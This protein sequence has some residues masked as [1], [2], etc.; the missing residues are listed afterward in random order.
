MNN[1]PYFPCIFD[2]KCNNLTNRLTFDIKLLDQP[3]LSLT[4]VRFI[5]R[6]HKSRLTGIKECFFTDEKTI[7]KIMDLLSDAEDLSGVVFA[8]HAF[9]NGQWVRVVSQQHCL[10]V[11]K[12]YMKISGRDGIALHDHNAVSEQEELFA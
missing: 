7:D 11:R 2:A 10:L 6:S 3:D 4:K 12:I 8:F 5:E 9:Q 1:T